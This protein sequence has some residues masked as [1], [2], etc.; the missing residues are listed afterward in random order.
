M[1]Q[2]DKVRRLLRSRYTPFFLPV[3]A[4]LAYIGFV[5]LV[6]PKD[7]SSSSSTDE[8][9]ATGGVGASASSASALESPE[10][11]AAKRRARLANR[12]PKISSGGV[13]PP[14]IPNGISPPV[15]PPAPPPPAP[16]APPINAD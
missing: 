2:F 5:V 15:P 3:V 7:L 4:S 13:I 6:I 14:S 11:I 16:A 1:A 8:D 12:T 9:N 10:M